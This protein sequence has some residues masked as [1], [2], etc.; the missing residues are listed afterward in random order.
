M[1]EPAVLSESQWSERLWRASRAIFTATGC[2][3]YCVGN[4]RVTLIAV[5]SIDNIFSRK[6]NFMIKPFFTGF[7]HPS[8][9]HHRLLARKPSAK[10]SVRNI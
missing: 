6:R 2:L 5:R 7:S 1:S 9:D 10:L 8:V 3:H 4:E